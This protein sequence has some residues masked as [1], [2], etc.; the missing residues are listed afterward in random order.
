MMHFYIFNYIN[1]YWNM[2]KNIVTCLLI[3]GA[4]AIHAQQDSLRQYPGTRAII[5]FKTELIG[6]SDYQNEDH[7]EIDIA[8]RG[9]LK[10]MQG[11]FYV[12]LSTQVQKYSRPIIWGVNMHIAHTEADNTGAAATFTRRTC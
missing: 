4:T 8:G 7:P 12:P 10:M 9:N 6:K 5:Y 3:F 1:I 11:G 2:K